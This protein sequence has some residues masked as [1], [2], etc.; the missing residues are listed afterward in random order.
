MKAHGNWLLAHTD[1]RKILIS[2]CKIANVGGIN[3]SSV[4]SSKLSG[5]DTAK[6]HHCPG[7]TRSSKLKVPPWLNFKKLFLDT[8]SKQN[9]PKLNL[10]V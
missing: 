3:V 8:W 10:S 2:D 1:H 9:G 5:R 4:Y 7:V 6:E